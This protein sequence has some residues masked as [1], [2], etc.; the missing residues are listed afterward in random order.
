MSFINPAVLNRYDVPQIEGIGFKRMLKLKEMNDLF[1]IDGITPSAWVGRLE[2]HGHP[3]VAYRGADGI[4]R[5]RVGE[6][7]AKA[8]ARLEKFGPAKRK[9]KTAGALFLHAPMSDKDLHSLKIAEMSRAL[10]G[11]YTVSESAIVRKATTVQQEKLCGVYFLVKK[12]RVVYVGQS[13]HVYNRVNQ[14]HNEAQKKFDSWCYIP[15]KRSQLNLL[16]SLYIHVLQ[17]KENGKAGASNHK[18]SPL[19]ISK[20][21]DLALNAN[22]PGSA[23]RLET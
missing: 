21:F 4:K 16:E 3:L 14:H 11:Q 13:V 8:R 22:D 19:S 17:P 5:Y 23:S 12:D 20:L 15:C 9:D 10:T 6:V 7:V 1:T 18:S 2:R